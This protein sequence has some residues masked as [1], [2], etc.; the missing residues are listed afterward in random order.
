[1]SLKS[2]EIVKFT[3]FHPE[4]QMS[5]F[6]GDATG[7]SQK[8]KV[9]GIHHLGTMNVFFKDDVLA[10]LPLFDREADRKCGKDRHGDDIQQRSLARFELW[11]LPL[12][13]VCVRPLS[14]RDIQC[15]WFWTNWT[16]VSAFL[17]PC[18]ITKSYFT[19]YFSACF[20]ISGFKL[21][22]LFIRSSWQL[23]E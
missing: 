5:K 8:I 20:W 3:I 22:V 2:I 6:H 23:V 4:G 7:K 9:I 10:F 14:H 13:G 21:P 11:M 19:L 1:M 16:D 12:C 15:L 17:S 18:F